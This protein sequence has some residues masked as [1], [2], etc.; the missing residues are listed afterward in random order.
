[1]TG[2]LFTGRGPSVSTMPD[3]RAES[4][5][6]DALREFERACDALLAAM[7][8]GQEELPERLAEAEARLRVAQKRLAAFRERNGQARR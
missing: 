6:R 8:D 7:R 4:E 3:A 1:M 5:L 2:K